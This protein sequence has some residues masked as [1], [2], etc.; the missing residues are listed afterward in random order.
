M[1]QDENID[2]TEIKFQKELVFT[3]TRSSGPGG[4]HVNKVS[5]RVELRFN[6]PESSLLTEDQK[7]VI[8]TRLKNKITDDG[9]LII[10]SQESRSQLKNKEKALEKFYQLIQKALKPVV[11][12]IPTKPTAGSKKK[13]LDY[14]K[15]LSEKKTKRKPPLGEVL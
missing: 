14:K 15:K 5:T 4:Q 13:R 3:A 7:L 6:I 11:K 8:L 9:T 12:R 2:I 10:V 1:K